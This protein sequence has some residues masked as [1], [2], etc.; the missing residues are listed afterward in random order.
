MSS[1][2]IMDNG[3]KVELPPERAFGER[4][5]WS[6]EDHFLVTIVKIDKKKALFRFADSSTA[7]VPRS[8]VLYFKPL[9]RQRAWVHIKRWLINRLHLRERRVRFRQDTNKDDAQFFHNGMEMFRI[10]G[11]EFTGSTPAVS[12]LQATKGFTLFSAYN[13]IGKLRD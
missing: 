10:D 11:Q 12:Y 1:L 2:A 13:V 5:T 9:P 4:Y 7:W 8:A 6:K 3:F